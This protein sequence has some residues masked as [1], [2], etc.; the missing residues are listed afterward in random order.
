MVLVEQTSK[1]N[2]ERMTIEAKQES[3]SQLYSTTAI[4]PVDTE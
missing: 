4:P 3:H 1:T 2:I